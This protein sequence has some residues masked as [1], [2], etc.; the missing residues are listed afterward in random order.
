MKQWAE[1]AGIILSTA[2]IVG[3]LSLGWETSDERAAGQVRIPM[4]THHVASTPVAPSVHFIPNGRSVPSAAKETKMASQVGSAKGYSLSIDAA[5]QSNLGQ[6]FTKAI[7]DFNKS[8]NK[9]EGETAPVCMVY[10]RPYADSSFTSSDPIPCSVGALI[11]W[12]AKTMF[13]PNHP[14]DLQ[15]GIV[16]VSIPGASIDQDTN[17]EFTCVPSGKSMECVRSTI[18]SQTPSAP[19]YSL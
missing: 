11:P 1:K 3:V 18:K 6:A 14:M 19:V 7:N 16:T 10:F 13:S 12:I 17:I 2:G 9:F 5:A 4:S 8:T 15:K